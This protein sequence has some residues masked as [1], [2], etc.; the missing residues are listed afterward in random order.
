MV[1]PRNRRSLW[2]LIEI[3]RR[4][5]DKIEASGYEVMWRRIRL[6]SFEKISIVIRALFR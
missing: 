5:L 4:L 6:T 3:Y 2:A 1:H